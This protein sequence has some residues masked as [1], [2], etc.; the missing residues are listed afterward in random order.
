MNVRLVQELSRRGWPV[1]LAVL[2]DR[3]RVIEESACQDVSMTVLNTSGPLARLQALGAL[4]TL[5]RQFDLVVGGVECAATTYGFLAARTAHRPF[6]AWMHTAFASHQQRLGWG[7]RALSRAIYRRVKQVV[8]PSHGALESLKAVLGRQPAAAQWTVIENFLR[9]PDPQPGPPPDARFFAK[10]VV[11]GIGRLDIPK[12]FDR[13]LR[14]HAA[15]LSRRIDHHL[16]ILGDGPQRAA[17]EAEIRHLGVEGSAFLLGH[18]SNVWPWFGHATVFALSSRYEGFSLAL[19]E[20]LAAGIPAVAM[21]CPSGP[22]EILQDGRYGLLVPQGDEAAFQEALARL[23]TD[24]RLRE[25][26]SSKGRERGKDFTPERILPKW[27]ALLQEVVQES[28]G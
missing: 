14:A 21:D 19:L 7:D 23:M 5:A 15:L 6:V 12:A 24:A 11:L 18:V 28:H 9:L 2:F 16:V 26:L 20:A 25:E 17:L 22:R 1:H 4:A 3:W 8:F 27:E 10:P 13:L